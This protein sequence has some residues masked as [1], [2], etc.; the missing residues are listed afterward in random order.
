MAKILVVDD[1]AFMRMVIKTM[2]E[3]NGHEVIA[4]ADNG[5]NAFLKYQ[6]FHPD[7]VI[8]DITMPEIDG[9]KGL[10]MII[11]SYPDAKVIMCSAMGQKTMI[12]DAINAGAKDFVVKPFEEERVMAAIDKVLQV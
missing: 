8:M 9:Q 4:E 3:K 7:L 11:N 10:E 2:L 1:A 12:L 5:R 6:S